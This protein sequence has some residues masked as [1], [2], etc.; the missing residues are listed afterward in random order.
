MT[1]TKL[2]ML[3]HGRPPHPDAARLSSPHCFLPLRASPQSARS[4]LAPACRAPHQHRS[5]LTLAMS[6]PLPLVMPPSRPSQGAVLVVVVLARRQIPPRHPK[7][8][9]SD[10][11]LPHVVNVYFRCFKGVLQLFHI[12]VAKLDRHVFAHIASVSEVCCKSLFKMYHLFEMYV[13]NILSGCCICYKG[14]V[15]S[16]CSKYFIRFSRMLQ[17]F[18]SECCRSRSRCRVVE[19]GRES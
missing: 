14:H 9:G 7:S 1:Q 2:I 10:P 11:P 15:A 12:D 5:L 16:V 13:E 6:R 8:T 3:G 17:L 19:S 18:L 4:L